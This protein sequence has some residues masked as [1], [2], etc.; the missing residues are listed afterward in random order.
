MA[1]KVTST[2]VKEG[3]TLTKD[4]STDAK[5][6]LALI[7]DTSNDVKKTFVLVEENRNHIIGFDDTLKAGFKSQEAMIQRLM[8]Q[9][10]CCGMA[11]KV[12]SLNEAAALVATLEELQDAVCRENICEEFSIVFSEIHRRTMAIYGLIQE[13]LK[14]F[15]VQLEEGVQLVRNCPK[16]LEWTDDLKSEYTNKFH[17]LNTILDTLYNHLNGIHPF[18]PMHEHLVHRSKK[19]TGSGALENRPEKVIKK[20]ESALGGFEDVNPMHEH[21]VHRSKK[22]TGSGALENRPEK[23]IKKSESAL[24][25]F[26]DVNP[27]HEHLVHRS[28]KDT[29]SGALENRPEKV[30]KKSESALGGFE[31]ESEE[32]KE[33]V[34]KAE[35]FINRFK[36]QLKLQRLDSLLR[37]RAIISTY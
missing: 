29:G 26:E 23:V 20:S 14:Y 19:D 12:G 11:N 18:N 13:K 16:V 34:S 10:Q 22:D 27:M 24:G 8:R 31:D 3:L 37:Y 15:R 7:K 36:Q 2:D 30:I 35:D 17:H 6:G 28:K 32:E 21:L 25:G 5:E 1:N 9:L 33:L 4:I